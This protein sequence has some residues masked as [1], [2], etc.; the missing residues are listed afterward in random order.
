[1]AEVAVIGAGVGGLTAAVD[2]AGRG[3]HVTVFEA[4]DEV[5]G[6]LGRVVVDG[7]EGDTGP[8]VLTLPDVFDDL[9]RT[10]GTCLRD[11]V[12]LVAHDALAD[13]RWPDGCRLVVHRD[14]AHTL[15]S[16]RDT[17][18][19]DAATELAA[20]L[21]YAEGIWDAAAPAFVLGDAPDLS[22]ALTMGLRSLGRVRRIDPMRTMLGGI[23]H[24]VSEP[25]LQDMLA[26]YATY[27]GS[28]PRQA[29]A[30]LNCIAHVELGLGC[31]GVRGGMYELARAL[32]RVATRL[33]ARF[34][35]GTPVRGLK[36]RG[37]GLTVVHDHG[38]S[39]FDA[40]VANADVAHVFGDL[41]DNPNHQDAPPS[42][43]GWTALV[44]TPRQTRLPHGVIFPNRYL[45]E[46]EDIFD[47]GIVPADPTVYVCAQEPSHGREGWS[48]DELLF[49][50]ANAPATSED[51]GSDLQQ[52]RDAVLEKLAAVEWATQAEVV[53][54]RTPR[55]LADAFPGTHGAIYGGSSNS[56]FA[57]FKRPQNRVSSIPG[58]YLA[59]GSAHPGGGVPLCALSGR[60]AARAVAEDT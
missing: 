18:G 53:W 6:K 54:E 36:R 30:T 4:H 50:M 51:R 58:L 26:R 10:V 28:D 47:R 33:G 32:E 9:F 20:F 42:M 59:S 48:D 2:L 37:G 5:G 31:Y 34:E 19:A 14:P 16:V 22:T 23:R 39:D 25:H 24:H 7:V 35:L 46:F 8:S 40:V 1:M 60:A 21:T 55:G 13:L 57:A 41:I 11:E 12:E 49:V 38:G 45:A 27:N 44:R 29:P 17:L 15:A 43:S 3:H 56:R 52:L